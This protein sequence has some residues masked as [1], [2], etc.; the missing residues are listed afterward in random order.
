MAMFLRRY[1]S[2]HSSD[3]LGLVLLGKDLDCG[4][5]WFNPMATALEFRSFPEGISV[6][7]PQHPCGVITWLVRI[8]SF[9]LV[10]RSQI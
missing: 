1:L 8:W 7:G 4:L 3:M 5:G 2:R 10:C 9:F 6:E